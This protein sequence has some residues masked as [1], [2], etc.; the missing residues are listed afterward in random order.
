MLKINRFNGE[1]YCCP[2]SKINICTVIKEIK[3]LEISNDLS[4]LPGIVNQCLLNVTERYGDTDLLR[5][6]LHE[7]LVNAIEYGNLEITAREKHQ[8]REN[9]QNYYG[10]TLQRSNLAKYLPRRVHITVDRSWDKLVITIRDEGNGFD[11]EQEKNRINEISGDKYK[12]CGR[13][14]LIALRAYDQVNY[15]QLGNKV[16]LVKFAVQT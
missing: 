10:Y 13:G 2:C 1:E 16:E 5:I 4:Q 9:N 11:W 7:L 8:F 3:E 14:I 15:N 12:P 6:G